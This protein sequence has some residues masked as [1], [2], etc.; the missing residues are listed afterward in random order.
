M[1]YCYL[2]TIFNRKSTFGYFLLAFDPKIK[3]EVSFNFFSV[4]DFI[5]KIT[6]T[7]ALQKKQLHIMLQTVGSQQGS[8]LD[9][10]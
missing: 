9:H 10:N 1:M 8:L 7:E 3:V 6:Q 2:F 4:L 5:V